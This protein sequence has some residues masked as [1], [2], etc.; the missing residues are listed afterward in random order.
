MAIR[1]LLVCGDFDQAEIDLMIEAYDGVCKELCISPTKYN[2]ANEAVA[3]GVVEFV[4]EGERDLAE[5]TRCVAR[6]IQ[7][8]GA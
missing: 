3:L 7:P 4:R 1:R 8:I 6:S 2:P 5:I